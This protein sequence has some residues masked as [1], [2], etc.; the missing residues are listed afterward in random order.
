MRPII[1]VLGVSF[2]CVALAAAQTPLNVHE[3]Q[4]ALRHYQAGVEFLSGEDFDKAV[5]EFRKAVTIDALFTDAYYGLGQGHMGL[6]RYVSAAQAFQSALTAARKLHS[7]N[8]RDRIL[9]ERDRD[10]EL[11]ELR[12]TLRRMGEQGGGLRTQ[13]VQKYITELERR[14]T[15]LDRPFEP[16]P[17]VLLALGSAHFRNGDAGRAEYYW[18]E[19]VRVD[20]T[21]GEA[22]NNLAAIYA[23]TGRRTDAVFAVANAE[24]AG[25]RVNPQ[26][27]EEIDKL[28]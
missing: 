1:L 15:S 24:R 13:R 27:K 21:I 8:E 23:Q 11:R 22:W 9:L 28:R 4:Q 5:T 26:L 14:R 25:Y 17:L 10:E 3:R 12:D 2:W 18:R 19:A 7:L 20:D 6:R 16:P